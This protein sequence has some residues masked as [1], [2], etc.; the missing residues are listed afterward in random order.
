[1]KT[2]LSCGLWIAVATVSIATAAV[3]L[4][5]PG[6]RAPAVAGRFYEEDAARLRAGVEAL[7][8]DAIPARGGE[9]IGLLAPH[10]GYVFSGQLAADAWRQVQDRDVDVVV[11]LG[12]NHTVAP[13]RGAAVFTG[14]G[15]R[16][17]L[18]TVPVDRGLAARVVEASGGLI[19]ANADAHRR[20][21]SIEV[22]LPFLQ[23]ALP[24]ARVLPLVVGTTD[25]ETCRRLGE[26]LA[27]A[28]R[29]CR[30]VIVASSDLCHYPDAATAV[31]VDSEVLAAA[32]SLAPAELVRTVTAAE[33]RRLPGLDTC[34]CGEGALLVML[35]AARGL[36]ANH[37]TVL[38]R[39]HS[40]D[41]AL[42]EPGR[43]VGYGALVASRAED[44]GSDTTAIEP[45]PPADPD[46][47]L[48]AGEQ[49]SLL[50]FARRTVAQYL[51]TGTAPLARGLAPRLGAQQGAFVTLHDERGR[52]RG[53]IG[54]LAEDRPLG[55]V[56]GAM[57]IQAAVGDRRFTPV[58]AA[59]LAGLRVEIS[60]LS[61]LEQVSGPGDVR[62]G[63]DGVMIRKDG[64]QAVFLPQ[65][66]V[67]QGWD[68]DTLLAELCRKA[69]LPRDAWRR[70]GCE[71]LT[72]QAQVFGEDSRR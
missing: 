37:A 7:L 4:P 22:Q 21:H 65:V 64:R 47:P 14:Q 59:E 52:L 69:G 5:D 60:V 40:G 68:R 53:C 61:P 13:F 39:V 67:E 27:D 12:T 63:T 10:A 71:F 57:A 38:D 32:A 70:P 62:V 29:D 30:P 25:P 11:I 31:A 6:V 56:V 49:T 26:V 15:L 58:D 1:M 34:A 9:P 45:P 46:R 2:R 8:R 51:T 16:T 3:D 41:T 66:A 55:V 19:A 18:G 33:R 43:V 20:E 54:H 42:G 72:F 48:D 28:L 36:G 50:G 24:G 44:P 23:A 17:P 35:H